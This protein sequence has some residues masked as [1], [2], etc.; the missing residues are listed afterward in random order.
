[1]LNLPGLTY[2]QR[3]TGGAVATLAATVAVMWQ[4]KPSLAASGDGRRRYGAPPG[5]RTTPQDYAR[6]G[7]PAGTNAAPNWSSEPRQR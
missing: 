2:T 5:K 6:R 3:L 7:K 4:P 1:M